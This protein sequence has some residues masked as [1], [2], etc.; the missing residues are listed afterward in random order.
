VSPLTGVI[1]AHGGLAAAL[2]EAAEGISGIHG[3]LVP[4]SN[5]DMGPDDLRMRVE[6]SIGTGSAVIFADLASGSC[7][8]A[9][10]AVGRGRGSVAVVTGV[11]LPMLLDFLFHRDMPAV[12]LANRVAG[13]GKNGIR[14]LSDLEAG[15]GA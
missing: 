11:S 12:E 6:A 2:V 10:R 14:V 7:T 15:D 1:V 4:I 9:G 13:K 5:Q 3:A 8:L